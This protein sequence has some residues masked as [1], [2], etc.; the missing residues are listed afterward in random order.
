MR[1]IILA[2]GNVVWESFVNFLDVRGGGG[3]EG[4]SWGGGGWRWLPG[5][6]LDWTTFY[7]DK[8]GI[9]EKLVSG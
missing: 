8:F 1:L 6:M 5:T 2:G 7:S 3:R 9:S 4:G